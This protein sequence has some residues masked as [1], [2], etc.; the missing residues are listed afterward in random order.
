MSLRIVHKWVGLMVGVQVLIWV[1]SGML[2]SLLDTNIVNGS[3]T[4]AN[5][6]ANSKLNAPQNLASLTDIAF[7]LNEPVIK[8]SLESVFDQPIYRIT[9]TNGALLFNALSGEQFNISANEAQQQ[10]LLS[11]KGS[12][13]LL[14]SEFLVSGS[15]ETFNSPMWRFD[16]SDESKTRVY[17]AASDGTIIAHRNDQ[18]QLVDFLLMLHFMEYFGTQGFNS[19]WIIFIAFLTLWL[20]ISGLLL[21]KTTFSK[22]DFTWKGMTR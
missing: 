9:T 16:F 7:K 14:K 8:V 22:R 1:F 3:A 20:T 6:S 12:G 5:I 4:R 11:Y 21:V 2:I 13:K 15:E 10:A 18:R 19:P 17:V